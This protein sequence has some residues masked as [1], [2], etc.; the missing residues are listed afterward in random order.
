MIHDE[1]GN[2]LPVLDPTSSAYQLVALLEYCRARGFRIGPYVKIG[3]VAAQVQDI[4]QHE[5][6]GVPRSESID[7]DFAT[8]LGVGDK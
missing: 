2:P 8:I 1:H 5:G 7:P 4:R 3:D 6:S